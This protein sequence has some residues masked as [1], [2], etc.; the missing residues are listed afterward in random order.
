M[1]SWQ[2]AFDD[3]VKANEWATLLKEQL[4]LNARV[5]NPGWGTGE[6]IVVVRMDRTLLLHLGLLGEMEALT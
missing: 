1:N 6:W 2:Y 5:E 4:A 3:F